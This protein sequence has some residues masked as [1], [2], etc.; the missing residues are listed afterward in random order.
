MES[1]T[2]GLASAPLGVRAGWECLV[3]RFL[4]LLPLIIGPGMF[5]LAIRE[6][7]RW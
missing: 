2:A 3:V 7:L 4:V 5:A 6:L 1:R